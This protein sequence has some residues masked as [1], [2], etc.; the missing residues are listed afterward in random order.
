MR[1]SEGRA[2]AGQGTW[3]SVL[4]LEVFCALFVGE[5]MSAGGRRGLQGI[6]V[7]DWCSVVRCS[8][9]VDH[10]LASDLF[11]GCVIKTQ[12]CSTTVFSTFVSYPEDV[13]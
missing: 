6:L 2:R 11:H 8:R 3:F 13:V 12:T 5:V 9:E 4:L 7:C 1:L 10:L